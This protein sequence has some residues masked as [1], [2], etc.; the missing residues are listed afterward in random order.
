[1]FALW[2][3]VPQNFTFIDTFDLLFKTHFVFGFCFD[4]NLAPMF[5]FIQEYFYNISSD[6]NLSN[7]MI[8][9]YNDIKNEQMGTTVG[10]ST[11]EESMNDSGESSF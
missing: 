11:L 1:M 10:N 5:N 9:F 8:Q 7:N 2:L 6:F 3:Q 4:F